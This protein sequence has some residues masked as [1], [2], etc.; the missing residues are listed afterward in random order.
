MGLFIEGLCFDLHTERGD[1][2]LKRKDIYEELHPETKREATLKQNRSEI[3]SERNVPSFVKDTA[4]K[5]CVSERT[6]E[7]E[8]QVAKKLTPEVKET[9]RSMTFQKQ[10]E[11]P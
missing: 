6:I 4:Q 1:L 10:G 3:I 9:V 8:I 5:T 7:H 2:L 11:K